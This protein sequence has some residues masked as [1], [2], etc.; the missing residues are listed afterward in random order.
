MKE[1]L[2]FYYDILHE[3]INIDLEVVPIMDG[4][5]PDIEM[6]FMDCNISFMSGYQVTKEIGAIG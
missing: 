6:I 4:D 3:C 5:Q 2:S 1:Y